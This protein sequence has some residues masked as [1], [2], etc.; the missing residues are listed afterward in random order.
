LKLHHHHLLRIGGLAAI[1]Q[2]LGEVRWIRI[3]RSD[4]IAQALSWH[5]ALDTGRWASWQEEARPARYSRSGIASR[6]AAIEQAELGWDAQLAGLPVHEV[7]CESLVAQP[8]EMVRDVLAWLDVP[9][10][11]QVEVPAPLLRRQADALTEEWRA[12]WDSGT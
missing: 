9:R 6:L 5:R 11:D 12:R 10:A 3:R 2:F 4:R 7:T 1:E 8:V